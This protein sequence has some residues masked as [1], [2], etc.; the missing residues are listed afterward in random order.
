[1]DEHGTALGACSNHR[2]ITKAGKSKTIIKAPKDREWV[3]I[4][5]A[6]SA[7]GIKIDPAIIFKGKAVRI[8]WFLNNIPNW[9][10]TTS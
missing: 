9:W 6:I 4:I 3:S 5:A 10:Y 1:M 7:A 2:V 8:S